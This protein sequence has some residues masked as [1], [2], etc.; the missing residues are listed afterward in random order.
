MNMEKMHFLTHRHSKKHTHTAHLLPGKVGSFWRGKDSD[1]TFP[2]V[3]TIGFK[4][5]ELLKRDGTKKTTIFKLF[6]LPTVLY[7]IS[8]NF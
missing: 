5:C 8:H 4:K 7:V 1:E 3:P 2:L 6:C